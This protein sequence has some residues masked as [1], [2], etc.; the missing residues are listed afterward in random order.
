M[1]GEIKNLAGV[2]LAI[3]ASLC[4]CDVVSGRLPKGKWRLI[5]IAPIFYVFA[6][7]P[8]YLTSAFFTSVIGFFITWL[9]SFKLLLFAFDQGPLSS[10][11]TKS[12]PIFVL[13][14]ALPLRIKPK[15]EAPTPK[16]PK[17]VL[18]LYL[19]AEIPISA[20]LISIV[21][22]YKQYIHPHI[23]LVVYICLIFLSMQISVE[24]FSLLVRALLGLELEP[25]S[26]EPYLSTSLQEFWGRRWN[27]TVSSIMREA[28]YKPV[29]SAATGAL[30]RDLAALPAVLAAFLVSGLMHELWFWYVTRP[31]S[32]SW[33]M[34][35]F[36][37]VQGFGLVVEFGLKVALARKKWRL[38]WYL[39]GP[40]TA[41]F[42]GV[43]SFWF[44]FPAMMRNGADVRVIQELRFVGE[45]VKEKI[46]EFWLHV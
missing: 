45:L 7:L 20:A 18:P 2:W 32:P 40:L 46:M 37:V 38:P 10:N 17:K 14:A 44:L 27:L 12:L 26:D 42:L 31:A 30:G 23:L 13:M 36:F 21:Y 16:K 39:S 5:S 28:V 11:P 22:D 34:T 35:M 15:N 24:L 25:P 1:E 4:Y 6:I 19:A 33:E 29:R 43:T 8:L 9:A 41:G 3:I